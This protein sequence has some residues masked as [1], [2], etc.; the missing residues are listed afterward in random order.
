MISNR[1]R[2]TLIS[3]LGW[4]DRDSLWRFDVNSSRNDR[5]PLETGAQWTSLHSSGTDRFSTGHHFDGSRFEISV[6]SFADP[7]QVLARAVITSANNELAG[8]L[9]AW[10][11]V[12][13]LY[14]EYLNF[15]PWK[16]FVLI[17]LVP[18]KGQI[19]L[20]RLEWYDSGYDKDYQGLVDTLE[21]PDKDLA[22]VSVQRSSRIIL[23]DLKA[24]TQKGFIDLGN[25]S[26]NPKLQFR[27][28][29]REIW[30]S[31]YDMILVIA[32]A[33]LRIVRKARLQSAWS[34]TQQF[35]GDFSFLP[36]A[37]ICAVARPFS[38][39]VVG[40]DTR[41]LRIK[42]STKLG[43]QPLEVAGLHDGRIIARDWKTGDLL[44]G[45]LDRRRFGR[46]G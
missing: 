34:G 13:R 26:G 44:R 46:F 27:D 15:H 18:S 36:D 40:I 9:S 6:R 43:R 25:R 4:V 5:L 37:D 29:A 45:E 32:T 14:L 31:D 19:E 20:Q 16:D 11:D 22:L 12:P 41:T 7:V 3:S 24:G 2:T 17:K 39:D 21:L 23:H 35:I 10:L 42:S 38:G 8:D 1:A 30:A 28:E 33:S